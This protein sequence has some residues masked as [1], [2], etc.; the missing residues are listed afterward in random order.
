MEGIIFIG[1]LDGRLLEH[2]AFLHTVALG[3]GTGG[4]IA[5]DHFQGYDA[6]LFDNRFPIGQLF[7]KVGRYAIALQHPHQVVAHAVVDGALAGNGALLQAVQRGGIILIGH[8]DIVFIL[9]GIDLFCLAFI[10]LGRFVHDKSL[11]NDLRDDYPLI[12]H[13]RYCHVNI[14]QRTRFSDIL[15]YLCPNPP[16]AI[17]SRAQC[18]MSGAVRWH[19]RKSEKYPCFPLR[20]YRGNGI[21]APINEKEESGVA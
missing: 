19:K 4:N 13:R 21:L 2:D 11:Q 12:L 15:P 10:K 8:D 17:R 14:A 6:Y 20:N 16:Q 5:D 7:H 3:E 1:E 9:C 18:A